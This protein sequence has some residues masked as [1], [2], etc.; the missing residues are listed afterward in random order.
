MIINKNNLISG[1]TWLT[2][3]DFVKYIVNLFYSLINNVFTL[4]FISK[5]FIILLSFYVNCELFRLDGLD[6][7]DENNN[8]DNN[9]DDN[10]NENN[11]SDNK[12]KTVDTQENK[13]KENETKETF[14][15][16][17][18]AGYMNDK[19][20]EMFKKMAS[21]EN[22]LL[23]NEKKE[24][25]ETGILPEENLHSKMADFRRDDE[26]VMKDIREKAEKVR[27]EES[28]ND[29]GSSA[30]KRRIVED[31]LLDSNKKK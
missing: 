19:F 11:N 8:S 15:S 14:E 12:D 9:S 1:F 30:N 5:I 7:S 24:F 17:H 16:K 28:P 20:E 23:E 26:S 27:L 2:L 18:K 31:N 3:F 21:W 22:Q 10:S 13:N 4:N 6:S 29:V 25:Q